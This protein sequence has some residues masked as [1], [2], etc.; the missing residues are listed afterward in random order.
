MCSATYESLHALALTRS[1]ISGTVKQRGYKKLPPVPV[2]LNEDEVKK[3]GLH[4]R[5]Y[6]GLM[7]RG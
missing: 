6:M 1:W 7:G 2:A 3:F 4:M 5:V